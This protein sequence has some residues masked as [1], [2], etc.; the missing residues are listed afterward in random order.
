MTKENE[1]ER[2]EKSKDFYERDGRITASLDES[3]MCIPLCCTS[4]TT[5]LRFYKSEMERAE[6]DP[7]FKKR[8]EKDTTKKVGS[9]RHPVKIMVLCCVTKPIR[10]PAYAGPQSEDSSGAHVTAG[11]AS[12]TCTPEPEWLSTGLLSITRTNGLTL[13]GRACGPA[14]TIAKYREVERMRK[15]LYGAAAVPETPQQRAVVE[16]WN[17][18]GTRSQDSSHAQHAIFWTQDGKRRA[19]FSRGVAGCAKNSD[20]HFIE[21]AIDAKRRVGWIDPPKEVARPRTDSELTRHS[22][23]VR[24]MVF[25]YQ[26]GDMR[27]KDNHMNGKG[28]AAACAGKVPVTEDSKVEEAISG[29]PDREA[30]RNGCRG[31]IDAIECENQ[32]RAKLDPSGKVLPLISVC[33]GDGAPGHG[34]SNKQRTR[35]VDQVQPGELCVGDARTAALHALT[36]DRPPPSPRHWATRRVV[37]RVWLHV[38]QTAQR[39]RW[40]KSTPRTYRRDGCR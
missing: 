23:G 9:K 12:T 14:V 6:R 18:A 1:E 17:A 2:L 31:L 29:M 19:R 20:G 32:I 15:K 39:S 26:K 22:N 7:A 30:D 3:Y 8:L 27:L 24:D 35:T 36:S 13:V 16:A 5:R 37:R 25:Y 21:S 28:F 10:N 11:S 33:D 38:M 4:T 40:K 34:F